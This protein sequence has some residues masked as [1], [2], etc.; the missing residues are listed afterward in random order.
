MARQVGVDD[1]KVERLLVGV[2]CGGEF[3]DG[4]EPPPPDYSHSGTL[5]FTPQQTPL[6]CRG[7]CGGEPLIKVD[8]VEPSM[9]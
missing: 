6:T 5:P 8:G 4:I 7:E 9:P 3:V 2:E 1:T